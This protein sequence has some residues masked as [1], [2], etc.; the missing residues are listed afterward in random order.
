M[1]NNNLAKF[2]SVFQSKVIS[3]LLGD[4][5]FLS[6]I[7]DILDVD[8]FD[9]QANKW[10]VTE[11][12]DYFT[13][14]SVAPTLEVF[15][16]KLS[17]SDNVVLKKTVVDSL[18]AI[19]NHMNDED[20]EY[21]K[22]TFR[23]FCKFQTMKAA[24]IEAANILEVGDQKDYETIRTQISK[25][26]EA[27]S[28]DSIGHNYITDVEKRLETIDRD[29][30]PTGWAV[31][32]DLLEGGLGSGELGVVMS[33]SG[34]GKSWV[35]C[36]LGAYA[37]W[38]GLNV[39]HYT[40]ELSDYYVGKRYDSIFTQLPVSKL[41]DN[42][43]KIIKIAN[44]LNGQIII[45]QYST[46]SASPQTIQSHLNRSKAMGIKYDLVIVD[47]ADLL[48]P[49]RSKRDQAR[50]EELGEIYED[51]RG[52]AGEYGAPVWTAS[53]TQRDAINMDVIQADSIAA[54]YQKVMTA[55]FI[56]SLSRK[57]SDKVNNLA[58]FHIVKNRLGADGMTFPATFDASIGK[59]DIT[60]GY[61]RLDDSEDKIAL[62]KKKYEELMG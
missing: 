26:L 20:R 5:N 13:Q 14:Y 30:V 43:D 7:H 16:V 19:F 58:R 33:S 62:R 56:I 35:L 61:Q 51:L 12:K 32:D 54:S 25:A 53:Q 47:Y 41:E 31:I 37:A 27:G 36:A 40:L 1:E 11:I 4:G 48:R 29:C 42:R 55:D 24:I 8:Y 49:S 18:R 39:I 15:K 38:H 59:I 6:S 57:A 2:G 28:T 52:L 17:E 34:G 23:D 46:K 10:I 45:K 21:V 9:N 60:V 44:S 50:H 22:D 3:C